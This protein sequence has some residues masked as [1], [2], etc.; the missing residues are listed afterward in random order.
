MPWE[1]GVLNR[2]PWNLTILPSHVTN[3]L[4]P[5]HDEATPPK[6]H[7]AHLHTSRDT[8]TVSAAS[9]R[10]SR[11]AEVVHSILYGVTRFC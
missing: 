9:T 1:R 10:S 5:A 8:R 3:Y 6:F 4:L 7:S 11:H 2:R